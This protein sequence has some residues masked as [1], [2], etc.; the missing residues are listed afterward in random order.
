MK[1]FQVG[2]TNREVT[3]CK[4]V[5]LW[6]NDPILHIL[7]GHQ[8]FS[9]PS[10]VI[11]MSHLTYTIFWIVF[12]LTSFQPPI[13]ST[14]TTFYL[15]GKCHPVVYSSDSNYSIFYLLKWWSVMLT[16]LVLPSLCLF[17]SLSSSR[18]PFLSP[19]HFI[20]WIH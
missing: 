20:Y 4:C 14:T 6:Q 10:E 17:L 8:K 12:S 16:Y 15:H 11:P 13:P 5:V 7:T 1:R 9:S 18:L 19:V 3:Y 2:F